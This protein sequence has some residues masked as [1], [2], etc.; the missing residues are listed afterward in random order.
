MET[1]QLIASFL[2]AQRLVRVG[3]CVEC[4][5]CKAST[6]LYH[7]AWSSS[8]SAA[9]KILSHLPLFFSVHC[10]PRLLVFFMRYE[11]FCSRYL[12]SLILIMIDIYCCCRCCV[13]GWSAEH[14]EW[15][16]GW[17]S[18]V[19]S[20]VTDTATSVDWQT[21]T[22]L[23]SCCR[24]WC[25]WWCWLWQWWWHRQLWQ[26]SWCVGCYIVFSAYSSPSLSR[27]LDSYIRAVMFVLRLRGKIIGTVPCSVVMSVVWSDT[28]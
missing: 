14:S 13:A 15:F 27:P 17:T 11:W 24:Q 9:Y 23:R 25:E 28:Q 20:V 16:E 2:D 6:V 8:C 12:I 10:F 21:F 5:L 18:Y 19:D 1:H 7:A 3:M 4:R 22:C 26:R